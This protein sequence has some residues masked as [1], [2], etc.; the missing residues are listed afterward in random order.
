MEGKELVKAE[1]QLPKF[2]EE[3][4]NTVEGMK[5]FA[6]ILLASKLVPDH[7]FEKGPDNK[8]D[9]TKGK[10]AAV[11]V[12]LLQAKQLGIPPMVGLQQIVPVNGLLS[13]KG[14]MCKTMI[15][16]S[17]KLQKDSWKEESS[18]S[19]K[20]EDY[21]YKITATRADNGTTI[22]RKFS[23]NAAKKAGL[24]VSKA[25][26]DGKDGWKYKKSS[27]W[28]YPERMC[29]YRA[30]GFVARDL[31]S[32]VL[33]NMYITEEAMDFQEDT[34]EVIETASGAQ[35]TIPDKEHV[36][37][38]SENLTGKASEKIAAMNHTQEAEVIPEGQQDAKVYTEYE[39]GEYGPKIYDLVEKEFPNLVDKLSA[40]PGKNTNKKWRLGVMAL[41]AGKL[42]GYLESDEF[43]E[44][45]EDKSTQPPVEKT[46]EEKEF[47]AN[48][49]SSV[50]ELPED[51]GTEKHVEQEVTHQG[52][53][54]SPVPESGQRAFP[55]MREV[56]HGLGDTLGIA[57]EKYVEIA[58]ELAD[59]GTSEILGSKFPTMQEFSKGATV[60]QVVELI[61]V[62][63]SIK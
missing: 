20:D 48:M 26:T 56:Y 36:K 21:E 29:G 17:G 47:E 55:D 31:F 38:R 8:P 24:W 16:N 61:D 62:Y 32:D 9:Y 51:P 40:L 54:I 45:K 2:V 10:T 27:W 11:V 15:F 35:I 53:I 41:Q 59:E 30:L 23:V 42:D 43:K 52:I 60:K 13:L 46:P 6:D 63:T 39:L 19:I 49:G 18:G 33:M 58:K 28:K 7:F 25:M 1:G 22:I 57:E 34:V 44:P 5:Q 3:S 12:V 14:D 50:E 37:E 4:Y